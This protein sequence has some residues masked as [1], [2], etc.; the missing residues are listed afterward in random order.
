MGL[1]CCQ[2]DAGPK[3]L[4]QRPRGGLDTKTGVPFGMPGGR[5]TELAEVAEIV[6]RQR[7]PCEM[8]E[9]VQ[10]HRAMAVGKDEAVPIRPLGRRRIDHEVIAPEDDRDIG[11]AQR[12][13]RMARIGGLHPVHCQCLDRVDGQLLGV[14]ES[15][16]ATSP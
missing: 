14:H 13:T 4:P 15:S 1:G 11:H 8:Q 10:Q 3:A 6:H 5:V 12:H 9:R 7:K 2:A 16:L